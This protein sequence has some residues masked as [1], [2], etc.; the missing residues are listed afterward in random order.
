MDDPG[1]LAQRLEALA[2]LVGKTVLKRW[3][4]FATEKEWDAL[5]G[6][7]L[8]L[9][10]D[11]LYTRSLQR[12]FATDSA[13]GGEAIVVAGTCAAAIVTLAAD[14]LAMTGAR[15]PLLMDRP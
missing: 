9:H 10:Y 8:S 7:L 3:A 11:P 14:V 1:R 5:I 13:S 2:P 6:E 4:A 12:Y 15:S